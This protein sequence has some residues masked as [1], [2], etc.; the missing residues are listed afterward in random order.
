MVTLEFRGRRESRVPGR[1]HSLVCEM[2]VAYEQVHYR[3]AETSRPSL[4]DGLRLMG[5][6]S[7]VSMT[8]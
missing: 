1:T 2:K 7:P 4:R 5:E 6:L 8:F 3:S